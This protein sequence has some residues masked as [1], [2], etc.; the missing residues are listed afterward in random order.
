MS[1]TIF[2]FRDHP[3]LQGLVNASTQITNVFGIE[4]IS[5]DQ[6]YKNIN[7]YSQCDVIFEAWLDCY[8]PLLKDIKGRKFVRWQSPS[9]QMELS[10]GGI[11]FQ[12]FY[13]LIKL[14][15]SNF[16]DGIFVT[17]EGLYHSLDNLVDWFPNIFSLSNNIPYKEMNCRNGVGLFMTYTPRKNLFCNIL[18]ANLLNKDLHLSNQFEPA[19]KNLLSF[20][21][22]KLIS[23]NCTDTKYYYK[24]IS[25]LFVNLQVTL[26][27]S[28]NYGIID[29]LLC[30]TP[31]ISGFNNPLNGFSREF[32]KISLVERVDNPVEI[33]NRACAIIESKSLHM[34][35]VC[36]GTDAITGY[37]KKSKEVIGNLLE[38]KKLI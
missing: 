21:D 35:A 26:S 14:K 17:D 34:D 4:A 13:E 2:I 28:L 22:V 10:P 38:S 8:P 33:K 29:S 6:F 31:I 36:Y 15:D 23:H 20:I 32:D 37:Y 1:K 18:A 5:V 7:L 3:T 16:I 25:K 12:I 24:I 11:E 27:E 30:G 9:T 19:F